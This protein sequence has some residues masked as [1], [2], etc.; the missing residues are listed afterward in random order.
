[1]IRIF[2]ITLTFFLVGYSV[3]YSIL[4]YRVCIDLAAKIEDYNNANSN[5]VNSKIL[6]HITNDSEVSENLF[7]LKQVLA[8][9]ML[10]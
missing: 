3:L 9:I 8:K 7:S 10:Y 5:S 4:L 2:R 1:M 6:F